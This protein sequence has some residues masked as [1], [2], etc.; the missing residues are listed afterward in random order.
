MKKVINFKSPSQLVYGLF[1][2]TFFDY[3]RKLFDLDVYK[4]RTTTVLCIFSE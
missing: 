2:Y 4:N 1:N 3:R